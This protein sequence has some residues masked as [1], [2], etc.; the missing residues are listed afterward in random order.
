MIRYRHATLFAALALFVLAFFLV[1]QSALSEPRDGTAGTFRIAG[2]DFGICLLD[3][4]S[5][6]VWLYDPNN[7]AWTPIPLLRDATPDFSQRARG[8]STPR[9]CPET[10]SAATRVPRRPRTAKKSVRR[11][12]QQFLVM[13]Q[14]LPP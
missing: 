13:L 4:R 7:K 2:T 11:P 1:G 5:A 8:L 12:C 10:E 3:T 6:K 9:R 14:R